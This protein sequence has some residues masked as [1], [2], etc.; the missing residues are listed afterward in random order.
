MAKDSDHLAGAFETENTGGVLS[1]LLAEENEFDRS[2]LWRIGSWG[3]A[4]VAAVVVA[5]MASQTSLGWRRDQHAVADLARQAQQLQNLTRE[6]QNETRRLSSAID[7][8][9]SDR[10]RLYSRVTV[11]EQGLDSVTGAIVRQNSATAQP[12]AAL[13]KPATTIEAQPLAQNK[14]TAPM[15]APVTTTVA[16]VTTT[17][18]PATTNVAPATTNVTPATTN[19]APATTSTAPAAAPTVL[20]KTDSIPRPDKPRAEAAAKDQRATAA[21]PSPAALPAASGAAAE[22]PP[23]PATPLIAAKPIMASP[24]SGAPKLLEPEKPVAAKADEPPA[25]DVTASAASKEP[26]ASDGASPNVAVQRTE[27]AVDVGGANSIGGLRALWRGLT[28]SNSELAALRPIIMVKE[29][30][31]GLGMQ[32]RLAAGPLADAAAA[33]KICAALIE[34]QRTCEMTVFDGQRLAMNADEQPPAAKPAPPPQQHRRGYYPKR[35]KRDDPPP[36]PQTSTATSTST[37]SRLFSR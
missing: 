25:P 8:L 3:V 20:A 2:T 4:A 35:S 34:N 12:P 32:L 9:N 14:A 16:P 23:T 17:V 7:T 37:L 26:D 19:V 18:A 21:S 13:S 5:V 6:S 24:D 1:G 29:S 36:T 10:D 28:K 27:F 31:T 30:A 11:L 15:V 22:R 33:A